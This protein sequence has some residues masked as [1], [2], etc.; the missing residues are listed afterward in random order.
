MNNK[1]TVSFTQVHSEKRRP[2]FAIGQF[3]ISTIKALADQTVNSNTF[4]YYED[5]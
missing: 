5:R 1:L 4:K 3:N 2:K